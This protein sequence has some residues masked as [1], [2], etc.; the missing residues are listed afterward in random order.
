MKRKVLFLVNKDNVIYNFRRELAFKLVELGYDV[1]IS[2]PYGKKIDFMVERGCKFAELNIDRR[3]TNIFTDIKLIWKYLKQLKKIK[4]DIVL[5]YTS[6]PTI[7]GGICCQIL[8]IPYI[9]NNA[10][11]L[12]STIYP[13]YV[14]VTLDFLYKVG[15]SGASCM[16]FQNAQEREY[17][18]NILGNKYYRDIPGSGVNLDLFSEKPYPSNDNEVIFNYVARIVKIKGIDELIGCA[19]RVKQKHQN[20]KFVLY[21][22]FDD[23]E[24]RKK[25]ENLQNDGIIEYGGI[26]LDIKPCISK[27]HAAIHP[28]YYEGM[29]NVVLE[30]GAMGRPS[31]GSNIPGVAEAIEVGKTGYT[32]EVRNVDS[33]VEA[34]EKFLALSN[35]EKAEMGHAARLKM[36]REFSRDIVTNVYLEEINRIMHEKD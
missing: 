35:K 22:D 8:G 29:T 31:L 10:G 11:L 30:H 27:A 15:Y 16:M 32:F 2:S 20:V 23:D 25:V 12:D 28:S 33:M 17:M 3:G 14:G 13:W 18:L 7:Y 1:Y 24:Y 19:I 9:V 34:V 4:P 26:Q 6:K 21:G 36:E 5:A